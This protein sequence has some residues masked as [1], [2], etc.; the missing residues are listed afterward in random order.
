M[1]L[2]MITRKIDRDDASPAGF[3]Y[4][5]VKKIAQKI[6][7]LEIICLEK[8]NLENLPKNIEIYSLG[9]EKGYGRI[10]MFFN[11]QK[12]AWRLIRKIDG[13]FCHQNP[14]YTILIWPYA[15]LFNK[16]IVSWHTHKIVNWK[17]RLV[18]ILTNKILTASVK[19]C[20]LK[21][22]KKVEIVGHGIDIDFFKK[23]QI[24]SENG[25]KFK[26]ISVGRISPVKDYET[27]IA[28]IEILA[29]KGVKNIEVKIIGQPV[30]KSDYLYK[31]FLEQLIINKNL[32]NYISLGKAIAH[33]QIPKEY[34]RADL[35]VNLS[36]T[37][38]VDKAVLEAMA[39]QC[40]V[41]T[42]NEAFEDI[43]NDKRFMFENKNSQNLAD[44]ISDL[45]S[46]SEAEKEKIGFKLRD[47]VVADHNLDNLINK[48]IK[49]YNE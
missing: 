22:K 29:K 10:R 19:S 1:K 11:F 6:D 41:L 42:C 32:D 20:R 44:K 7:K 48:I 30:L 14:E 35:M 31:K 13:V 17:V 37:G 27:L 16:K 21:N 15:K 4:L 34:S 38:S 12:L 3:T 36:Q 9:K 2:L 18:N 49:I 45:F 47:I 40:L 33:S 26:I 24:K 23:Q 8:G 28:A 43:L 25:E 46:L 5:W 39:C